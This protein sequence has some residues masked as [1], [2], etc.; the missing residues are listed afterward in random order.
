MQTIVRT[1]LL[2]VLAASV[3]GFAPVPAKKGTYKIDPR[4]SQIL[5]QVQHMKL[6][7]FYGRL[8]PVSGTLIFDPDA[9]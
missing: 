3:A 6:S 8:G 5:F 2:L 4:H 9:T 1:V 7:D